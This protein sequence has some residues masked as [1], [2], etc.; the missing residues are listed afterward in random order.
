ML[1]TI[2]VGISIVV[3]INMFGQGA[4]QANRDAVIQDLVTIGSRAQEW[5]RKPELLGGGG[6]DFDNLND[7]TQLGFPDSTANGTFTISG[8]GQSATVSGTDV[9]TGVTLTVTVFPDSVGN[10]Q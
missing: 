8:S 1:S 3:G 9:E 5:Y 2:I 6:R 4:I 10:P 7:V